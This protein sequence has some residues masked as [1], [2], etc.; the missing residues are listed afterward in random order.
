MN[1]FR[2]QI[3]KNMSHYSYHHHKNMSH[4]W[5]FEYKNMSEFLA[6]LFFNY[7]LPNDKG[8]VSCGIFYRRRN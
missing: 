2:L 6:R 3:Y 8:K 4:F 7:D 5:W 1:D